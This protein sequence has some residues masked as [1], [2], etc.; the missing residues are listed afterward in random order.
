MSGGGAK[1]TWFFKTLFIKNDEVIWYFFYFGRHHWHL[2]D[3]T[4]EDEGPFV[5]IL[6]SQ[7]HP[8]E[9][10]A[11][12]LDEV[13]NS[14]V[15]LRELLVQGRQIVRRRWDFATS[16]MVYDR[17]VKPIEVA[18]DFFGDVILKVLV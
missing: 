16:R 17:N 14:P 18:K 4:I 13:E 5:A 9:E 8:G 12:R 7:Q 2:P 11:T 6:V 10:L 1:K 15:S 3:A